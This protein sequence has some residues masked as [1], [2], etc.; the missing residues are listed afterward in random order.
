MTT[1][2]LQFKD[3]KLHCLKSIFKYSFVTLST[4]VVPYCTLI[5]K[6]PFLRVWNDWTR[7][8]AVHRLEAGQNHLAL[9]MQIPLRACV[10]ALHQ[11]LLIEQRVVRPEGA[12]CVVVQLVVVAQLRLPHGRDVFVHVHLSAHGHHDEDS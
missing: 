1:T 12:G 2:K 4:T 5:P 9:A 7:C 10:Q 11:K 8:R 6:K 3:S